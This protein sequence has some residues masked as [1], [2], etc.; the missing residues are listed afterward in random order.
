MLAVHWVRPCSSGINCWND[1]DIHKLAETVRRVPSSVRSS[2]MTRFSKHCRSMKRSTRP[3]ASDEELCEV[4]SDFIA[5]EKVIGWFQ[6]RME[7]GPRALGARSILGDARSTK[8]QSVMNLKIKCRESF[9]PFAPIVL[10][11]YVGSLFRNAP[12]RRQS[13]HAPCRPRPEG[14]PH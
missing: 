11:E 8:M 5:Q 14:H 7:F 10:R 2:L 12:A 9:R 3:C 1:R 6:G 4:V 13:V